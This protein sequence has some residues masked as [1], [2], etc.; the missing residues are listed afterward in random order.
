MRRVLCFVTLALLVAGCSVRPVGGVDGWKVYGPPGPEGPPGPAGAPGPQGIA[1]LPGPTGPQGPAGPAGVKGPAGE[2]VVWKGFSDV[3][4]DVNKSEIRPAE[5][6][7]LTALAAWMKANPGLR[8]EL[9]A[10][11]DPRGSAAYNMQL[12]RRRLEA[13]RSAL[14]A[15]GVSPYAI[16]TG[17][18]GEMNP[19][20]TDAT[21]TCWQQ[22]R[23]VEIVVVPGLSS[24]VGGASPR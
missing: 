2:T 16:V 14:V 23:R 20:C 15:A 3:L 1:G 8:V 11:A 22:D 24:D 19:K 4:F 17:A 18:Y 6:D 5:A 12:S 13:V 7:K 9:E 21:E 10:F